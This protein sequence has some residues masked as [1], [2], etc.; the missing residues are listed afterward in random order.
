M[1]LTQHRRARLTQGLALVVVGALLAGPDAT[2]VESSTVTDSRAVADSAG[3]EAKT[4][5]INGNPNGMRGLEVWRGGC[6]AQ[7]FPSETRNFQFGYG[8]GQPLPYGPLSVAWVPDGV[9]EA[10]AVRATTGSPISAD[11]FDVQVYHP[12][13]PVTGFVSVTYVPDAAVDEEW[14]GYAKFSD[15]E[16]GWH[17][18]YG[19][20]STFDWVHLVN[21]VSDGETTPPS[22]LAELARR[23]GTPGNQATMGFAFGCDGKVTYVDGLRLGSSKQGWNLYDMV[24]K[25]SDISLKISKPA[26]TCQLSA[27]RYPGV[28]RVSGRLEGLKKW[29][30]WRLDGKGRVIRRISPVRVTKDG[31]FRGRFQVRRSAAVVAY[32]PNTDTT[33]AAVSRGIRVSAVPEIDFAPGDRSAVLG[34]GLTVSGR[35]KPGKRVRYTAL[36]TVWTG[37]RWTPYRAIGKNRADAKGRFRVQAPTGSRGFARISILTQ[38]TTK[39]N[40]ALSRTAVTYR[41]DPRRT[42]TPETFGDSGTPQ[43][44]GTP[45]LPPPPPAP[46]PVIPGGG[47]DQQ[48]DP[49]PEP[50]RVMVKKAKSGYGACGWKPPAGRP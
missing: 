17:P 38:R 23:D 15:D 7:G 6:T 27:A 5:R 46:D 36:H 35:I 11:I 44:T 33:E 20:R 1:P 9:D 8:N 24:G 22:T 18:I 25:P 10:V 3:G 32:A 14:L 16:K 42:P 21:G 26:E 13:P 34:D 39:T 41:V 29:A 47:G 50:G 43:S 49:M 31:R 45:A 19:A 4:Y 48:P 40:A 30:I 28:V 2:A 37:S 12:E